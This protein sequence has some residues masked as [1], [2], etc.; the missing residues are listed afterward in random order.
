M[1]LSSGLNT[2]KNMYV[3]LYYLDEVGSHFVFVF[4][5]KERY[6]DGKKKHPLK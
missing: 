5:P 1:Y 4:L 3:A 6:Q 2:G